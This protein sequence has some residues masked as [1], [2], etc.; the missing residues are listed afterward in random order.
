MYTEDPDEAKGWLPGGQLREDVFTL[1]RVYLGC[2]YDVSLKLTIPIKLAPL[3]RLGDRS[4]LAGYN[5]VL[6]LRE[7]NLDE[8]PKEVTMK[9]GRISDKSKLRDHGK[10]NQ[11]I[12]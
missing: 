10:N 3:P 6:G 2:D 4:L 9:L 1:L 11:L 12:F 8:M 5:I 7:D